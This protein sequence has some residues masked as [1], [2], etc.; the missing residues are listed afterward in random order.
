MARALLKRKGVALA[1]EESNGER[2]EQGR[3][4]EQALGPPGALRS[5]RSHRGRPKRCVLT[6][7]SLESSAQRPRDTVEYPNQYGA[8]LRCELERAEEAPVEPA[9]APVSPVDALR[10]LMAQDPSWYEARAAIS[11]HDSKALQAVY[12]D[13]ALLA[14]LADLATSDRAVNLAER[15][16]GPL[17]KQMAFLRMAKSEAAPRDARRAP[18]I[19][20]EDASVMRRLDGEHRLYEVYRAYE[21]ARVKTIGPGGFPAEYGDPTG[22]VEEARRHRSRALGASGY[23][24]LEAFE[25]DRQGFSDFVHG[26][27]LQTAHEM[28]RES[29]RVAR[30]EKERYATAE[31]ET[32]GAKLVPLEALVERREASMRAYNALRPSESGLREAPR[33]DALA[34]EIAAVSA[35]I[36]AMRAT[37]SR[38]YPILADRRID[39]TALVH[40][41]P[42][43]L[44]RAL[45]EVA[46]AC[47]DDIEATH[48]SL[49]QDSSL[50]FELPAVLTRVKRDLGLPPGSA[51]ALILGDEAARHAGERA[52]ASIERAALGIALGALSG[53]TGLLAAGASVGLVGLGAASLFDGIHDRS[54]QSR[55]AGTHFD[56]AKA[57][58]SEAPSELWLALDLVGLIADGALAAHAFASV[59]RAANRAV[60]A[61]PHEL[62]R[63]LGDVR[64]AALEVP[65]AGVLEREAL[66]DVAVETARREHLRERTRVEAAG[67]LEALEEAH[68][69]LDETARIGLARLSEGA[70]AQAVEAFGL[71][72]T[73]LARV[74]RIAEASPRALEGLERLFG[75]IGVEE[76]RALARDVAAAR[77]P[78]GFSRALERL[79]GEQLRSATSPMS[80]PGSGRPTAIACG[81][82][83]RSRSRGSPRA[84]RTSSASAAHRRA[85]LARRCGRWA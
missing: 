46:G 82:S 38:E 28:L 63:A 64:R 16:G 54:V 13:R 57:L 17:S 7:S 70:R 21:N 22:E 1:D 30:A 3:R 5:R 8:L 39:L 14:S 59:A 49:D 40:A 11:R 44:G 52:K 33:Q 26:Y 4:T 77:D 23:E 61:S 85:G 80:R 50:V 65:E 72:P 83:R 9:S 69:E 41:S 75:A 45:A 76:A 58:A 78:S 19:S 36:E 18:S 25:R 74:G 31:V 2:G 79:G 20:P 56:R 66:G 29:A 81:A 60:M 35:E 62:D 84:P 55:A 24:T 10:A 67:V 53:G 73:A 71:A 43:K 6:S 51:V 47:L 27:A 48:K 12:E 32:L 68:P 37:L 34:F 42:S 15:I